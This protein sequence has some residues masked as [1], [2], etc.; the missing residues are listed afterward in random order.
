LGFLC[1]FQN[2]AQSKQSPNRLKIAQSG[3]DDMILKI[4][5]PKNLAKIL[6]FWPTVVLLKLLIVFVKILSYHMF[7]RKTPFFR[8][9]LAKNRGKL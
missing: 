8:R 6:A 1:I 7:L 3:T 5:S 2:T 9:K 4:F